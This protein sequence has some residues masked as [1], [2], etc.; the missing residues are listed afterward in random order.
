MGGTAA[1]G[2]TPPQPPSASLLT[3]RPTTPDPDKSEK[4]FH[5]RPITQSD[6]RR[7]IRYLEHRFEVAPLE[8]GDRRIR[9]LLGEL[10]LRGGQGVDVALGQEVEQGTQCDEVAVL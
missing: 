2:D 6:R 7:G 9:L 8:E 1:H 10:D 3:L 4:Q 5:D